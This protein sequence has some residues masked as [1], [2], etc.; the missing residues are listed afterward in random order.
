LL[1]N[2]GARGHI[3]GA[4]AALKQRVPQAVTH[5]DN[6]RRNDGFSFFPSDCLF[7]ASA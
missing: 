1:A 2:E 4:A 5:D 7:V 6:G 3:I